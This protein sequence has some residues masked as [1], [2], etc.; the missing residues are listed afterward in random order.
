[1]PHRLGHPEQLDEPELAAER[2]ELFAAI[3]RFIVRT[4][5][6]RCRD[7]QGGCPTCAIWAAR[8]VLS[9]TIFE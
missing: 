1:M 7:V 4:Y 3:D 9:A 8:D 6:E 5:G 2:R